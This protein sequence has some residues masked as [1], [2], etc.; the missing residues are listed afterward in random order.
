MSWGD[1]DLSTV[2]ADNEQLPASDATNFVIT[3]GGYNKFD[4]AKVDVYAKVYDGPLKGK[5]TVF[6]YPD[7]EKQDWS[8]GVFKRLVNSV[9]GKME[10]GE[11]PVEF[12]VRVGKSKDAIFTAPVKEREFEKDGLVETR[13]E[14]NT[15]KVRSYKS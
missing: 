13:G 7:P 2:P 10:A 8:P 11:G 4:K 1:I 12:L 15:W 6:S 9:G 5:S 3:G 14:V